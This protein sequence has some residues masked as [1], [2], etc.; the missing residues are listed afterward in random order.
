MKKCALLLALIL[1]FAI[2]IS[3][4]AATP[5][6][7]GINPEIVF[8]GSEAICTV[9]ILGNN[10]SE[11][12]EATIRLWDGAICQEIW[13]ARGNG[14]IFFSETATAVLGNTYELTVSVS[15]NGVK[16]PTVSFSKTYT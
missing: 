2:P 4:Q 10:M 1:L 3:A 8:N 15:I 9:R 16:Q 7:L 14:Y 6:T 13:T 5:R 12:I 11:K